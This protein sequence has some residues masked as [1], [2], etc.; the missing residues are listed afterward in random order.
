MFIEQTASLS[1]PFSWQAVLTNTLNATG[2]G[3]FT[4]SSPPAG[5]LWFL[6]RGR[7]VTTNAR[8]VLPTL[9]LAVHVVAF[10]RLA[11]PDEELSDPNET[12]ARGQSGCEGWGG[13][14]RIDTKMHANGDGEPGGGQE[15]A[16][17]GGRIM[18]RLQRSIPT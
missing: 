1:P 13:Q 14:P 3:S 7:A 18:G 6:S 9:A 10:Y 16:S 8:G 17:G 12:R 15:R 11:V 2:Q 5:A 4:N